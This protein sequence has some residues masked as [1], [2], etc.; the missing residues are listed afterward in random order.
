MSAPAVPTAHFG[1]HRALLWGLSY[2]MTGSAADADDLVQDTML[3]ALERP[4]ADPTAP[5]P[6]LVTVCM[7]LARDRLRARKR[8]RYKGP[9]LPSPIRTRAGLE[10]GDAAAEP[11]EPGPN[12]EARLDRAESV[13][14]AFLLALEVLTPNERAVLILREVLEHSTE[15]TAQALSL[16]ASNVKVTLL[17]AKRAL[18]AYDKVRVKRVRDPEA[19]RAALTRFLAALA[20]ED[21]AAVAG[22]LAPTARGLQDSGGEYLAAGIPLEGPEA[23][24]RAWLGIAK[25]GGVVTGAEWMELNGSWALVGTMEGAR[26]RAV[27]RGRSRPSREVAPRFALLVDVDDAGAIERVYTVLAPRKLRHI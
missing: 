22:V 23:L 26:T 4:P 15:E 6:W 7:N 27:T 13:T 5:R 20:S 9:W 21:P 8:A 19:S 1:E 24:A 10:E 16:S 3:R 25:K 11:P 2:R 12:A 14:F 17:R 18:A